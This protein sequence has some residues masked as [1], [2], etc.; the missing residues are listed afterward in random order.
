MNDVQ[1]AAAIDSVYDTFAPPQGSV[2]LM[3]Q[4]VTLE[5]VNVDETDVAVLLAI[6]TATANGPAYGLRQRGALYDA[7]LGRLRSERGIDE[8][9]ELLAGLG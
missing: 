5:R 3:L 4:V 6:L 9:N 1:R 2:D 7:V 8:A